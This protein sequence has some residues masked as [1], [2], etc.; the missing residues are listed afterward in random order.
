M[1]WTVIWTVVIEFFLLQT[2]TIILSS[3]TYKYVSNNAE[4]NLQKLKIE[5]LQSAEDL[6]ETHL[7]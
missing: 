3:E 7:T 1:Y 5:L 2:F 4:Y 6:Q